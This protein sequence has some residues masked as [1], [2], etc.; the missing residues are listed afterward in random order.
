MISKWEALGPPRYPYSKEQIQEILAAR[1][2]S[3]SCMRSLRAMDS[4]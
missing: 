2:R 4:E 3:L 1:S